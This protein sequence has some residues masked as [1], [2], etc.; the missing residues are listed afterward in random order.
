MII[1]LVINLERDSIRID[2]VHRDIDGKLK[3]QN[4][5][6]AQVKH[7]VEITICRM[8]MLADVSELV[9]GWAYQGRKSLIVRG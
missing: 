5:R 8:N 4:N 1:R 3:F 2:T 7:K 6:Q 9:F